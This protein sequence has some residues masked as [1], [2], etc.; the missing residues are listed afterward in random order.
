M[1]TGGN[2][3]NGPD[4]LRYLANL[5]AGLHFLCCYKTTSQSLECSRIEQLE[6]A[7]VEKKITQDIQKNDLETEQQFDGNAEHDHLHMIAEAAECRSR[8]ATSGA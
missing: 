1:C 2:D 5:L 3:R 7:I 6:A 8:C 4:V